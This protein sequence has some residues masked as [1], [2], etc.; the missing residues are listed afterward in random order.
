MLISALWHSDSIIH[1][2]L[3]LHMLFH[4][5]SSQVIEYSFLTQQDPVKPSYIKQFTPANPRFPFHLSPL[6]LAISECVCLFVVE[7][8]GFFTYSATISL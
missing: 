5:G 8:E 2:Y 3:P 6:P 7:L 1:T 4:C